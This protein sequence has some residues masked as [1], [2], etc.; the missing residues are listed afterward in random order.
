MLKRL[1]IS[2]RLLILSV[3]L[4]AVIAGSNLYLTAALRE[5]SNKALDSDQVVSQIESVHAVRVAF[6]DL[7]YWRADLSVSLL[8]LSERNADAARRRLDR[9]LDALAATL[10]TLAGT[11]R[12]EVAAFDELAGQAVD[13]YTQDRRVIGN[14]LFAQARE[15]SLKITSLLDDLEAGLAEQEKAARDQVLHHARTASQVSLSVV[16]ISVLLGIAL[17]VFILR[18]ILVPLRSLVGAVRA[19]SRGDA[20]VDLPP[21]SHDEIGEMTRALHLFRESLVE[22]DRLERAAEHQ[23]RTIQQAVEALN[24]GFVLYGP[25]NRLVLCNSKYHEIY[26]GI[27]DIAVPGAAFADIL[28][29]AVGRSII[30]LG[31][32][33]AEAWIESRLRNHAEPRGVHEFRLGRRWVQVA[34]RKTYD[35]GTVAVHTDITELKER[36]AELQRAKEG[37][38][39]ATQVKSEFLANMSHELRTPLNAI[40]GYSQI[41][42][43]DAQ[44]SGESAMLPDLKKIENAGNHLLG[45]INSILDLSKIEAGRMEVYIETVNVAALVE[46]VR[47]MVEP[48][49][50]RNANRLVIAC[51]PDAGVISTDMTKLKQALLNLLS[52]ASKFTDKGT[53]ILTAARRVISGSDWMEFTVSDTGIG[54]TEAQLD[55]LFQAFSQADSSTTRRYGGTGLGLT[56]TRSFARMLGGDVTVI[57]RPGAGSTFTLTLPASQEA[58][59]PQGD[60][61]PPV[62]SEALATVL[63]VDDDPAARHIIGS[64][65]A[66]DGYRLLYATSGQEALDLAREHR[67]DAITLDIMMP[68]I[69]GWTVLHTLKGDRELSSIPVVL[70]TVNQDRSLGFELGAVAFLSKPVDREELLEVIRRC[71]PGSAHGA[72]LVVEDEAETRELTE[73]TIEKLG[74]RAV[75]T[76]NGRQAIAWLEA[77]APPRLILLD[78]LMP[79]MDGF[80][81]LER[82]RVNPE[83]RDIPVIVVTAKQL[84]VEERQWLGQN[85]QQVIAKGQSAHVDLSQSVR[86]VLA[87]VVP[88]PAG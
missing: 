20:T 60:A 45:L 62:G 36:Q 39:L 84:T 17:T 22:R 18:S 43:E 10:P 68:Q 85:T 88:A 4:L 65:L 53:V 71:C 50:A 70:V 76:A 34:E 19:I 74:F 56:I 30:E 8:M 40:I 16:A 86:A 14:S 67:P 77:N 48:L 29:A 2:A 83:W 37:A 1:S 80:G 11:L 54:M 64:H 26:G 61:I 66:R 57:S 5:A 7:R 6:G 9:Q 52:N 41:L 79:E 35:G 12:G 75:L 27:A 25:D 51:A 63:I 15:H 42:Q 28:R 23:R 73:R 38:E 44:D 82:L 72:V 3:T 31:G 58:T 13:A 78:L 81:F 46:D 32:L 55:G 87:R 59:Q 47:I 69:D 24:E 49:A 21:P 33:S